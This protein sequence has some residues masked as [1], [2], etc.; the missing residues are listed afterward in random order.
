MCVSALGRSLK[1]NPLNPESDQHLISPYS[2]L[3]ESF[4]KV[5]RIKEMITTQRSFHCETNSPCQYQRKCLK[6]SMENVDTDVRVSRVK[7]S[8]LRL[9]LLSPSASLH[10]GV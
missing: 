7:C 2:N 6:K 1:V 9:T 8:L 5:M 4:I 3:A 10:P